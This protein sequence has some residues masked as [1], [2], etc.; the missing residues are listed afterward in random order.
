MKP[1]KITVFHKII[2][3]RNIVYIPKV[4]RCKRYS[5]KYEANSNVSAKGFL[6]NSEVILRICEP[7]EG[8]IE[9][10]D[11]VMLGEFTELKN[12]AMTVR[13]VSENRSGSKHISHTKVVCG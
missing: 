5:I 3:D 10:G 11:R 12:N 6:P 9:T 1:I 8:L 2:S 7:A 13:A 4:F